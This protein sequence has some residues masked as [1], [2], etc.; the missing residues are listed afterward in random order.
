[1]MATILTIFE[2]DMIDNVK[3][4]RYKNQ[5]SNEDSINKSNEVTHDKE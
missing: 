4:S 5:Q 1:M 3:D 2:E